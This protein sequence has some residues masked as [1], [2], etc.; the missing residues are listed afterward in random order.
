MM[1]IFSRSIC[2]SKK[3]VLFFTTRDIKKR[4]YIGTRFLVNVTLKNVC[5]YF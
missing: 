3:G 4:T 1:N 2:A 5:K